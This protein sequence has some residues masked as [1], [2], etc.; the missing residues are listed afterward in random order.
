G[1]DCLVWRDTLV[2]G[3][4][5]LVDAVDAVW[6]GQRRN[7]APRVRTEHGL[8][9]RREVWID[10][11]EARVR[12]ELV[13]LVQGRSPSRRVLVENPRL[14]GIDGSVSLEDQGIERPRIVQPAVRD[15]TT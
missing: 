6:Q 4:S 11:K 14:D 9:R 12:S 5:I 10:G 1:G 15:G 7:Q 13:E 2:G 3:G 8:I